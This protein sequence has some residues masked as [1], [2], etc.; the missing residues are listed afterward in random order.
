[1][2][3][4]PTQLVRRMRLFVW[5]VTSVSV[6]SI[7]KKKNTHDKIPLLMPSPC[8]DLGFV[9]CYRKKDLKKEKERERERERESCVT[10][11]TQ[12][13]LTCSSQ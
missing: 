7:R 11:G 13:R 10:G 12:E 8:S 9:R 6:L 5:A 2:T 4:S 3:V 1:M